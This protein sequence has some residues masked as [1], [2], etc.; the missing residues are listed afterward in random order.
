[1]RRQRARDYKGVVHLKIIGEKINGTRKRVAQAIQERDGA[2]IQN[3]AREQAAAG[4]DWLDANAG[5]APQREPDDLI[6]LVENI[7][8]AVDTPV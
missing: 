5:T 4:A 2:F 1:M 8:T 7:Q 3:L 6:W